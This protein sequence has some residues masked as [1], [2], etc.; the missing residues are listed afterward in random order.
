M[1][2]SEENL[3]LP[4]MPWQ[5]DK[6]K[7][8]NLEKFTKLT[9]SK[10]VKNF[11]N[12]FS[13]FKDYSSVADLSRDIKVRRLYSVF[14]EK[15]PEIMRIFRT[16][17]EEFHEVHENLPTLKKE[18]DKEELVKI[19]NIIKKYKKEYFF[20][21]VKYLNYKDIRQ[22]ILTQTRKEEIDIL[23]N[24]KRDTQFKRAISISYRKKYGKDWRDV[25]KEK[26]FI[27]R[28]L[29][30][31]T[32][33]SKLMNN[34]LEFIKDPIKASFWGNETL[35]CLKNGGAA[36]ALLK[37]I[38]SSP[39]A[40]EVVGK[41]KNKKTLAYV[42]DMLEIN[43]GIAEKSLIIDNIEVAGKLT[44]E[45]TERYLNVYKNLNGYKNIYLGTIRNDCTLS[46]KYIKT[47]KERQSVPTGYEKLYKEHRFSGAD[48]KNLYTI[49][50]RKNDNR[51]FLRDMDFTDL[52]TV[53]YL[54]KYLYPGIDPD[55]I[56]NIDLETPCFIIDSKT[57]VAGYFVTR[58]KYFKIDETDFSQDNE[59]KKKDLKKNKKYVKK[60]YIEDIVLAPNR[61]VI[62]CLSQITE[63]L[64]TWL[65]DNGIDT[66][67]TNVN[68]NSKTLL[69]RLTAEGI[70]VEA[71]KLSTIRPEKELK[72]LDVGEVKVGWC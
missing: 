32:Y 19:F 26:N 50:I 47:T 63:R 10:I 42:W 34:Q 2:L 46:E 22:M 21:F 14:K 53:K 49:D 12:E 72:N 69:K 64:V 18:L 54:E 31:T 6:E 37:P 51:F 70:K 5:A 24:K 67:M 17:S 55:F 11:M 9:N 23:I 56:Y 25:V 13:K 43:N 41:F 30:N 71:E 1:V 66:L 3:G 29:P 4:F 60:F 8:Q 7:Y 59:I 57:H 35:C 45:E 61:K 33:V 15:T 65:K 28:R 40:G 20:R 39:L 58:F 38:E 68:E 36:E 62:S 52:H 48:S 16:F 44:E 27:E